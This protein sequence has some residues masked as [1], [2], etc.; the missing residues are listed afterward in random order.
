MREDREA[1]EHHADGALVRRHGGDRPAV[2]IDLAGARLDEAGDHAEDRR[3]A[4]AARPQQRDEGAAAH[5]EGDV[6]DRDG[7]AVALGDAVDLDTEIRRRRRLP[8]P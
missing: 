6:V 3:L 5:R 7:T 4:R 8:E 1:L 2:D